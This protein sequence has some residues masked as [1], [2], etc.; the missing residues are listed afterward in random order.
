MRPSLGFGAKGREENRNRGRGWE[1]TVSGIW[2]EN[3]E[4][5]GVEALDEEEM[6]GKGEDRGM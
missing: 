2:G 1:K 6:E 3:F 4:T 5:S